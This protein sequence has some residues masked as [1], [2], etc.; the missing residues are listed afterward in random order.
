MPLF[1]V[2]D[3]VDNRRTGVPM[4]GVQVRAKFDDTDTIAPIYADQSGTAFDPLNY[5]VTDA[6]G[7]FSFYIDSG[8]YTLEF[9]VGDVVLKTIPDFRP[10]EVGP[11]G[12]ANS[13]YNTTEE[14]ESADVSNVSAILAEVSKVGTFTT[15]DYVD[16]TAQVAAD[17]GKVNYIRSVFDA[18]KVWV[19]T[20]ILS[21]AASQTGASSGLTVDAE[22]AAKATLTGV[23]RTATNLGTF[24]GSTIPDNQAIK[25]AMQALE[26]AV[27]N[28]SGNAATKVNAT[29]VGVAATDADMGTTPGTI[30]SDNGTAKQW[31]QESEAAIEQGGKF[32]QSGTGALARTGQDKAREWVTPQDFGAKADHVLNYVVGSMAAG[33]NVLNLN[34]ALPSGIT[35]GMRI[36][37]DGAGPGGEQLIATITNVN[38]S[39]TIITLGSNAVRAI[40]N[41]NLPLRYGTDD[42]A[43][44]QACFDYCYQ[45]GKGCRITD[46]VYLTTDTLVWKQPIGSLTTNIREAQIIKLD[47]STGATIKW[48]SA[49]GTGKAVIRFG[50]KDDY[51]Q[52]LRNGYIKGG[53]YDCSLVADIGVDLPFAVQTSIGDMEIIDIKLRGWKIG[54]MASPSTSGGVRVDNCRINRSTLTRQLTIT[55]ITKATE[56]VVTVADYN[57]DDG[58]VVAIYGASGMTEVNNKFYKIARLSQNT[59]KLVGT[60]S[61]GWGTFTGT[62]LVTACMPSMRVSWAIS[63]I[64]KASPAVVTLTQAPAE[65]NGTKVEFHALEGMDNLE[66]VTAYI[67]AVAGQPTKYEL[68]TDAGLTTPLNSSAYATYTGNG[69]MTAYVDPNTMETGI[70]YEN[71]PDNKTSHNLFRG[72]RIGVG[73]MAVNSAGWGGT[74]TDNHFHNFNLDGSM[75]AH[76]ISGGKNRIIAPYIDG[77]TKY[78]FI[79]EGPLNDVLAIQHYHNPSGIWLARDNYP[80]THRTVN[81]GC[82]V[83]TWGGVMEGGATQRI[84]ADHIGSGDYRPN[85]TTMQF[86]SHYPDDELTPRSDPRFYGIIQPLVDPA[87]GWAIDSTG[88]SKQIAQ[89]GTFDLQTGAGVISI[90]ETQATGYGALLVVGNAGIAIVGNTAAANS[91]FKNTLSPAAGEIGIAVTGFRVRI[92]NNFG[93][94]ITVCVS[95]LRTRNT[96]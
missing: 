57:W 45:S 66:A 48:A 96:T 89:S 93:S 13:T 49:S 1:H 94:T 78:G 51:E 90:T 81:S 41:R 28:T 2:F 22:L 74:H 29:A 36:F 18:T 92:T 56:A 5:C 55:S 16:F 85:R 27:E 11:S 60:D 86:V 79:W 71:G 10:A 32:L 39:R 24:A 95:G 58:R 9:L 37:V 83:R 50:V 82:G 73:G 47:V 43:A 7:M 77:P 25:A 72:V 34:S 87:S 53:A 12:P 40:T 30:L 54:D 35:A 91:M 75:Y 70:H 19:R 6:D 20:S 42:Y 76:Y 8:E 44:I 65:A 61:T 31:F 64:T 80:I 68:Y 63:N 52:F 23:G 26:T 17:S 4:A 3:L 21:D 67:K 62:A 14:L 33:S 59:F 38:G 46:G 88:I 69:F 84:F 15:R